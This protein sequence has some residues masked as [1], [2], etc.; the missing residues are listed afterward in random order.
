MVHIKIKKGLDIPIKGD[1]E[2][3]L[4]ELETNGRQ[5]IALNLEPFEGVRFKLLAKE[6]DIV[7]QG[8]PL[9]ED[10][11]TPGRMFVSPA[12]GRVSEVRRGLKRRLIDIVID[13]A[14]VKEVV[15]FSPIDVA[16]ALRDEL[17][18]RLMEGGLFAHIRQ[19]PFNFLADPSKE[20]RSIFVKALESVPFAV[21]AE[22][23]VAGY[24]EDFQT[25]LSALAK[26]TSGKVHLVYRHD[27]SCQAFTDAYDV[28]QH[29]A[30]G[31]HPI[32]NHSVH[33]HFIDPIRT[34]EDTVWTVTARD[35]VMIGHLLNQ[36]RY[37]VEKIISIGGPGIIP[38]QTGYFRTRAGCSISGLIEGRISEGLIRFISG[39]VL[40]GEKVEP[41]DF[42]GFYHHALSVVS[43]NTQREFL[44]FFRLGAGKYTASKTYLSGHLQDRQYDFTTNQHGEQRGFIISS[45]YD[46]VMPMNIPTMLLVKAVIG[47]DFDLAEEQGLLEVD[48]EDFA[49]ATFCCPSKI[50]MVDIMKNAL[51]DY[52]LEVS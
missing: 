6:G 52:A 41:E 45:P 4:Q 37:L 27:S 26:M 10:K 24:E 7:K 8:Q 36:G 21:P 19:R 16:T 11:M 29:T 51:R 48:A 23:Q 47:E 40:M 9:V 22:M 33:I 39:D 15:A 5:Q 12:S 49:L 35:V 34:V 50:E 38:G 17:V 18:V 13:V 46:N 28:E 44:H 43:E 2:G 1:P 14:E 32:G 3:E 25:G 31:P 20:P 42:L 30:Q